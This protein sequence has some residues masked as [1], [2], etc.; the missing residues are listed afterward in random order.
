MIAD[1]AVTRRHGGC[2]HALAVIEQVL[3][4]QDGDFLPAAP[5]NSARAGKNRIQPG[6]VELDVFSCVFKEL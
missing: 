3:P 4:G 5:V 6:L 1:L 2:E